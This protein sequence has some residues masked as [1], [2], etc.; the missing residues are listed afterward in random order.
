MCFGVTQFA[1]SV[2]C[3]PDVIAFTCGCICILLFAFSCWCVILSGFMIHR[4][5]LFSCGLHL[6]CC[7]LGVCNSRDCYFSRDVPCVFLFAELTFFIC[8]LRLFTDSCLRCALNF[9]LLVFHKHY[10]CYLAYRINL[11]NYCC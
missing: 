2:W 6:F 9:Y 4:Y 5:R 3:L 7:L 11:I 8:S 1:F 10:W